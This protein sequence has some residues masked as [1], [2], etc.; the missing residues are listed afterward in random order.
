MK[1]LLSIFFFAVVATATNDFPEPL[2]FVP[3]LMDSTVD[4]CL[5]SF[6]RHVCKSS[7]SNKQRLERVME[8]ELRE[9]KQVVVR[10]NETLATFYQ[11][12]K[13]PNAKETEL[14][15]KHL[16]S[17]IVGDFLRREQIPLVWARLARLQLHAPFSLRMQPGT[18]TPVLEYAGFNDTTLQ[19]LTVINLLQQTKNIHNYNVYEMQMSIQAIM[20]VHLALTAFT[21]K[22]SHD[23]TAKWRNISAGVTPDFLNAYAGPLF[24]FRPDQDV[25]LSGG[26]DASYFQWLSSLPLTVPE[27]RAYAH[28]SILYNNHGLLRGNCYDMTESMLPGL[29]INSF[30]NMH[31]VAETVIQS[32]TFK[33]LYHEMYGADAPDIVRPPLEVYLGR[34]AI[35][36][37]EANVHMI[38]EHELMDNLSNATVVPTVTHY[39][40]IPPFYSD[41]YSHVGRYA[42]TGFFMALDATNSPA[43]A[44]ERAYRAAN[45]SQLVDKQ[46]FFMIVA[47]AVCDADLMD[48]VFK[49]FAP[50]NEVMHC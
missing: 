30:L 18:F 41:G 29:F 26:I 11:S 36:Q 15:Y 42:L 7:S 12:C 4:M 8:R 17:S 33:Q 22:T 40:M 20:K 3:S 19:E 6:T 24:R 31:P 46:H 10:D 14:E 34:L 16:F 2:P 5:Q 25:I 27:W 37:F 9:W 39:A 38:L 48:P 28:F 1:V 35:D 43:V 47:Q 23:I 21:R 32:D 44:L 49:A 45:L 13:S 50:F